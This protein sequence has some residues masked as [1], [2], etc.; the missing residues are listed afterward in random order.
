M[1]VVAGVVVVVVFVVVVTSLVVV[2]AVTAVPLVVVEPDGVGAEG[3]TT[4]D[5]ARDLAMVEPLVL[6]AVTAMCKVDPTSAI[7]RR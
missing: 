1:V 6:L 2:V 3:G 4:T 5:V 7:V